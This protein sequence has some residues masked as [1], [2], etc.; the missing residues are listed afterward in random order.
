MLRAYWDG[1]AKPSVETPIGDFFG[2]NLNS[3]VIY[4]PSTWPARPA[5][6]STATS[7]CRTAVGARLTVTNEGK[8]EVGSFYSNIDYMTVPA[9]PEDALYFHAQYRQAAAVRAGHAARPRS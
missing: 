2:L 6:R 9:L 1:N 3:Y 7:P 5:S 4:S 8:Q